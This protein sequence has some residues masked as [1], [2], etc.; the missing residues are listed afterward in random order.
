MR[1]LKFKLYVVSW[2]VCAGA[3]VCVCVCVVSVRVIVYVRARV[4]ALSIVS[5]SQD[6][7]LH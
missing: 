1:R 3:S 2:L 6:F 5:T 4:Y 7:V